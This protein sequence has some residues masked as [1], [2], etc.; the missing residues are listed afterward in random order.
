MVVGVHPHN[1]NTKITWQ[2]EKK[3]EN[4]RNPCNILF[5]CIK[6]INKKKP[7]GYLMY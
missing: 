3:S 5:F 1:L 2:I 4:E 7:Y 6:I